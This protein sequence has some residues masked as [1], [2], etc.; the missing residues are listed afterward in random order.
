MKP[1]VVQSYISV[2]LIACM[3]LNHNYIAGFTRKR[4]ILICEI[5][6]SACVHIEITERRSRGFLSKT[7]GGDRVS[8]VALNVLIKTS[9]ACWVPEELYNI[10]FE[11]NSDQTR[12]LID[13]EISSS[14]WRQDLDV[15]L[16]LGYVTWICRASGL[17][18]LL[19]WNSGFV[20]INTPQ[21]LNIMHYYDEFNLYFSSSTCL[22]SCDTC[23]RG[24]VD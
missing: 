2:D 4:Y 10:K 9:C 20:V 11:S 3:M 16:T 18:A 6:S 13:V 21:S 17:K 24:K 14:H 8:A 12:R 19:Q 1:C 5:Y 22:L 15:R 7:R 23:W